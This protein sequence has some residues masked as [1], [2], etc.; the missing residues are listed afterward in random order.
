MLLW[1]SDPV[2][3]V[4]NVSIIMPPQLNPAANDYLEIG[5][6]SLK[7]YGLTCSMNM[8]HSCHQL[9][10]SENESTCMTVNFCC[11]ALHN[12]Q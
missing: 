8:R 5:L 6:Y 2:H 4:G 1:T 9:Q 12:T 3:V 10:H 7:S 11:N